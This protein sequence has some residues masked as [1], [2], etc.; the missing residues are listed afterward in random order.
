MQ[1]EKHPT[2]E[3]IYLD[4]KTSAIRENT[5]NHTQAL[6]D[7]AII[8]QTHMLTKAY[9]GHERVKALNLT[10]K[11]GWIYGF[12]GPNGAGKSTTMKMLLG[13]AA[14]TSGTAE[15]FGL[16]MNDKNRGEILR[17]TGS[18]IESPGYYGHLSAAENLKILETLLNLPASRSESAL[19][20]VRLW[21]QKDRKV[22]EYSLGMK[23]R[24]AI[25]MA[26]LRSPELLIL[27]EPTNGLDPAGIEEIRSLLK[28]LAH[29]HGITIMISSHLLSEIEKTADHIGIIDDGEMIWQGSLA[30]LEE[31]RSPRFVVKTADNAKA[32]TLL[33]ELKPKVTGDAIALA[34]TEPKFCA[35]VLNKL[36][37]NNVP[38]YAA[39]PERK[40]LEE[41]FL[42][43]TGRRVTL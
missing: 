14:P 9:G 6:K 43:I 27:D 3:N 23:Q 18:I 39:S 41:L 26:L 25:A 32:C 31:S 34:C 8:I 28:D 13:L 16:E 36:I 38:V 20:L 11:K 1:A 7:A 24:L 35:G 29:K 30:A 33:A 37:T 19:K 5:A 2:Q 22:K 15:L 4:T 17:R 10:V 21:E 40:N 12:L 42:D